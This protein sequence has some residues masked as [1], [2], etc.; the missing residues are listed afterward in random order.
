MQSSADPERLHT[1]PS[2]LEHSGRQQPA[3]PDHVQLPHH[4][5][6]SVETLSRKFCESVTQQSHLQ[7]DVAQAAAAAVEPAVP[8]GGESESQAEPA[9]QPPVLSGSDS[10]GRIIREGDTVIL[11]V[12]GEKQAFIQAQKNG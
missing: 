11:D 3:T 4:R 5:E 12:N 7:M 2:Q 9:A 6:N 1:L 8:A 10:G